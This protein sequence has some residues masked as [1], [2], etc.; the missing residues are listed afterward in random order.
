MRRILSLGGHILLFLTFTF[1]RTALF[2]ITCLFNEVSGFKWIN[3]PLSSKLGGTFF[4]Q[5]IASWLL[6]HFYCNVLRKLYATYIWGDCEW[7][8][9]MLEFLDQSFFK[10]IFKANQINVL[11]IFLFEREKESKIS[12]PNLPAQSPCPTP[13]SALSLTPQ[14]PQSPLARTH[15]FPKTHF[16]IHWSHTL[17]LY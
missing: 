4:F 6:L 10:K 5:W 8:L 9:R 15:V 7:M 1:W 16:E 17:F 13:G 3:E 11:N 2:L 14:K 12:L